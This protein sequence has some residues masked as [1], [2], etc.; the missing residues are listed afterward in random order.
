MR[1]A[2][3]SRRRRRAP[4]SFTLGALP[5]KRIAT[6]ALAFVAVAVFVWQ[7]IGIER[8]HA[9]AERLNGGLAFALLTILPLLGFPASVLHVAAGIRFG[10]PLGLTLVA[11]SILLQLLASYGLVHLFHDRFAKWLAPLR[12]RIPPGAHASICVLAVLLPGA[13]FAAVNYVLPL[14]GVRLRTYVLCCLPIHI[15][16]ST[17]TVSFGDQSDH[18][19]APRLAILIA[20]ALLIL[21]AS[22]WTYRRLR[23]QLEG[24]PSTAGGRRQP[25]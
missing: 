23:G 14:I 2:S 15:L 5:W 22:W 21:G 9:Y 6:A 11:A 4:V 17:V 19:T 13:P 20:Y 3:S 18:L 25:A 7:G 8:I 12:H 10:I 16:R 1:P 24:R